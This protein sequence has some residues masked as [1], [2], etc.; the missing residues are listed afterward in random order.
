MRRVEDEK[1]GLR[2]KGFLKSLKVNL[3]I[4]VFGRHDLVFSLFEKLFFGVLSFMKV[5]CFFGLRE[6]PIV[7]PPAICT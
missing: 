6:I 3:P 1:L 2:V 7:F 4:V 5:T